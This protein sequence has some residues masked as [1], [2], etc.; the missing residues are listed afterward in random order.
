VTLKF[1][2]TLRDNMLDEITAYFGS[3]ALIRIY[4][5]TQPATGGG[6]LS[7]NTLLATLTCASPFAPAASGG[8][9]DAGSIIDDVSA[10]ATGTASWFRAVQSDGT[11]W[12]SDGTVATSGADLNLNTVSIKAGG[13]VSVTNLDITAP[14]AA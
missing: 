7:G 2:E 9:L 12:V 1:A 11:T 6:A 13:V 8:L 14:N 3:A 5:G 4:D 10:D